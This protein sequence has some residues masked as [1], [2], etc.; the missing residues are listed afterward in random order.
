MLHLMLSLALPTSHAADPDAIHAL[1]DDESGWTLH[2]AENSEG[3][4]VFTKPVPSLGLAAFKGV[5]IL[6]AGVDVDAI[7]T[8][9]ADLENHDKHSKHLHES[10]LIDQKGSQDW[11]YEVAKS[12]GPF[13]SE[14]YWFNTTISDKSVGGV[15][16]H[17]KRA[18]SSFDAAALY[19]DVLADV[20]TRYPD[21]VSVDL[22]YGSWEWE[23]QA[24]GTT[25]MTYRTVT[26]PGGSVPAGMYATVSSKTL[27]DN[28]MTFVRPALK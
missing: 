17:Y 26:H 19:P 14:R 8:I 11:F 6:D 15:D 7:Y 1:L 20:N 13:I 10:T 18:W 4:T 28:M 2:A 16:G 3:I 5:L 21:A 12:P 25:R 22:T 27:P 23:P 24:D 9:V